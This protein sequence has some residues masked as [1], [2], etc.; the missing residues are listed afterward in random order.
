MAL[1][2]AFGVGRIGEVVVFVPG[3]VPGDRV[4]A[5]VARV[6]KRL[7]YGEILEIEELSP[8]REEARCP[9]FGECEG[10]DL[11]VLAYGKQLEIKENHLRQVLRRVGGPDVARVAVS[12]MV[13][14]V[15]RFF[16]RS[17]IEFSFG[18][19]EGETVVGMT[20]R[21]SPLRPFTGRVL[22]VGDCC[23]FSPVAARIL[24]PV[25]DFVRRSGLRAFDRRTG[26]GDLRRLVLREAKQTGHVMVNVIT[27][28]DASG[29]LGELAGA[30]T[31]AVPE[32]RS[33]YATGNENGT[34]RP[35]LLSG[36]AYLEE[37][38]GDLVLRVYPLSF[39]QPNPR[40]AQELCT[41][42]VSAARI[43]GDEKV[44]G[45]YC[46]AG[47]IELFLARRTS[48][49]TGV[50]SSADSISCARENAAANGVKNAVFV[51][52]KAERAADRYRGK[53]VDL[54]VIDPPRAGLSPQALSAVEKVGAPRLVYV[55]CD[56]STLARDLRVLKD[57][58]TVKEMVPFDFFPQT[59]HFEVLTVLEK[60]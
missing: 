23:L 37:T 31:E 9:H 19:M 30:L 33:V 44:L 32:V 50:D 2:A 21:V 35:R 54:V 38:L 39:F 41:R 6:E 51:R 40:T 1:P 3:G 13:P 18:T 24:G 25:R 53:T 60:R 43:R 49:V 55:S 57:R 59:A 8:F 7:A 52:D 11:Q 58:Y 26:T 10:S 27:A 12:P 34:D 42:I 36:D 46:G 29:P 15:D 5:R 56:P 16:Y 20:E 47:A 28:S 22:A 14:S 48:E 45:L 17:K 4:K